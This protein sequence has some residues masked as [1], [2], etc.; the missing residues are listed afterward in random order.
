MLTRQGI[1]QENDRYR[2]EMARLEKEVSRLRRL[3]ASGQTETRHGVDTPWGDELAGHL[4]DKEILSQR[5]IKVYRHH[6][7]Q[8]LIESQGGIEIVVVIIDGNHFRVYR[9]QDFKT[10]TDSS[11][12]ISYIKGILV[13]VSQAVNFSEKSKK[14]Y[15]PR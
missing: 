13:G 12:Q 6:F 3:H 15:R 4:E 2:N 5:A 14:F 8:L 9:L 10:D 1:I 11:I 7:K